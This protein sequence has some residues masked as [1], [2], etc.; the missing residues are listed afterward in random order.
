MIVSGVGRRKRA[1]LETGR[2]HLG[3]GRAGSGQID[4]QPHHVMEAIVHHG[5]ATICV[6]HAKT[7][8]HVVQCRVELSRDRCF[9]LVCQQRF[10]KDRVKAEIDVLQ[11]QEEQH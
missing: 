8:R 6:E 10:H 5:E 7:M 11:T 9:S 2:D 4:F 1:G 3:C